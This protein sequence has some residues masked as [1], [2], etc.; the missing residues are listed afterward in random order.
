MAYAEL[1]SYI[2]TVDS[3]FLSEELI[4]FYTECKEKNRPE[5][6]VDFISHFCENT[7]IDIEADAPEFLDNVLRYMNHSDPKLI[8]KV[9]VAMNSIFNKVSKETQFAFVPRIKDS[10]ENECV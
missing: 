7:S 2:P 8:E 3:G 10:I 1:M 6:Y 9:I 4:K 5:F